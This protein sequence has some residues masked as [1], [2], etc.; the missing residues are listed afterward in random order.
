MA[1]YLLSVIRKQQLKQCNYSV[2]QSALLT[3]FRTDFTSSVWNF[4]QW[5]ADVS[6]YETSPAAKSEEKRMLSQANRSEDVTVKW[7]LHKAQRWIET[8]SSPPFFLRDSRASETRARVKITL[9][10][11]RRH[12]RRVSPFLAL[13]DF[14]ERF[15]PRYFHTPLPPL[16]LP[17]TSGLNYLDIFLHLTHML[18]SALRKLI[19]GVHG[20]QEMFFWIAKNFIRQVE[21]YNQSCRRNIPEQIL[22]TRSLVRPPDDNIN[23]SNSDWK[24]ELQKI[25]FSF[26]LVLSKLRFMNW[27]GDLSTLSHILSKAL[28]MSGVNN[29]RIQRS[30]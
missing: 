27:S 15:P 1:F 7:N 11:E 5:V 20:I 4:C 13:G 18:S 26:R 16:P 21:F 23:Q 28:S 30:S 6:S 2:N 9:R 24:G 12:A 3:G 14:H 17:C 19:F 25:Q 22:G 10:E 29:N 8:T